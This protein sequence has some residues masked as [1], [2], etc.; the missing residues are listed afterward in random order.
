MLLARHFRRR[1]L[2]FSVSTLGFFISSFS[3]VLASD[4]TGPVVSVLDGDTIEVLHHTHPERIRLS[5]IDCPVGA[6]LRHSP[7]PAL[8][9]NTR[10]I[11]FQEEGTTQGKAFGCSL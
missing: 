4:F 7:I 11:Y 6:S 9:L 8:T 10:Q 1:R 5:G 3:V 2:I